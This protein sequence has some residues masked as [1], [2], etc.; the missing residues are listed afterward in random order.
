MR[1]TGNYSYR[2][3]GYDS[4]H[5]KIS[6]S[7]FN[8]QQQYS[9]ILS[10]I[11]RDHL[12]QKSVRREDQRLGYLSV[13]HGVNLGG[14][15][16]EIIN[17]VLELCSK[18]KHNVMK[19]LTTLVEDMMILDKEVYFGFVQT[20]QG[21]KVDVRTTDTFDCYLGQF[22]IDV[23]NYIL[24]F[25]RDFLKGLV[26]EDVNQICGILLQLLNEQQTR[27]SELSALDQ[28]NS[29]NQDVLISVRS[30]NDEALR[31]CILRFIS[32]ICQENDSTVDD[33]TIKLIFEYVQCLAFLP[34]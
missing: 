24:K 12:K 18:P 23:L 9:V 17:D 14:Y 34:P 28:N 7:N 3:N 27:V 13:F 8:P 20:L 22:I 10:K 2:S 16:D 19:L 33:A 31:E 21:G 29:E 4:N 15:C 26:A 25:K 5:G 6:K 1:S 32:Q 30:V 11:H